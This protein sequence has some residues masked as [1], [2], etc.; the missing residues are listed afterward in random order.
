MCMDMRIFLFFFER[1]SYGIEDAPRARKR[2]GDSGKQK[3][4]YK[5]VGRM[6]K[7][8]EKALNLLKRMAD[9]VC[10]KGLRLLMVD[11]VI[12]SIAYSMSLYLKFDGRI[13]DQYASVILDQA[14]MILSTYVLAY[15]GFGLYMRLW[16]YAGI[17]DYMKVFVAN[18]TA[19]T[20]VLL[21]GVI[22]EWH[23]P[24]SVYVISWM[25]A[26]LGTVMVRVAFRLLG[27]KVYEEMNGEQLPDLQVR[28]MVVGAGAT[29]D[30][31]IREMLSVRGTHIPVVVVDD[32]KYKIGS[33]LNGVRVRGSRY[34]I[35]RLVEEYDVDEIIIAIPSATLEE[36]KE[37]AEICMKTG[38]KIKTTPFLRELIEGDVSMKDVKDVSIYDL[39]GREEV[40]LNDDEVIS[41]VRGKS[42][43]V[44]GGGGSIGS[45][46]CRQIARLGARQLII[47]DI[48]ENNAYDLQQELLRLYGSSL[49]LVTLI[50]S[51]R[52]KDRLEYV[53][54]TYQ[55]QIVFHAAAHKHVPLMEEC[56][57]EAFKNNV[58][59][60]LNVVRTAHEFGA[61]SMTL[62]STDKAVNPTNIMGATKRIAEMIV[63][64][65]SH[66]SSTKFAAVRFGNVL[67][68][69][70]SVIPLFK[71]QIE[72]GGP[73]TVTDPEITRYF[74]TIPEASKLVIRAGALAKGGEIF[75]LDMGEPIKI[76]DLARSLIR[77]S[78]YEPDKDI[79]IKFTGLRPGEK[80]YEELLLSEEGLTATHISKI[81]VAKPAEQDPDFDRKIDYLRGVI[82]SQEEDLVEVIERMIGYNIREKVS[83]AEINANAE[84]NARAEINA[85]AGMINDNKEKIQK[86]TSQSTNSAD[87]QV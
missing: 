23:L 60:T 40:S 30:I 3:H 18:V 80:L 76:V 36:K 68:S 56:P 85:N 17:E 61:E 32:D 77:L 81:Y 72:K 25:T 46:I 58:F 50:G 73:V 1:N 14:I 35:P 71:K 65:Y 4:M 64:N 78:G 7:T 45:E 22:L 42:V 12:V 9:N 34:E 6:K 84:I 74:M 82:E 33:R 44:T 10:R 62:I 66:Q 11:L 52:E 2:H 63:Q 69:N 48:Y 27:R 39:L 26:F 19:S 51:V 15:I 13:P 70:G 16:D 38:T 54:R 47:F 55:P 31:L 49:N 24:F 29:G 87:I 21:W 28:V 43:L 53:F 37:I 20:A 83:S 79:R 75:I 59:G 41:Y 57:Y 86:S 8:A 5:E 67:G